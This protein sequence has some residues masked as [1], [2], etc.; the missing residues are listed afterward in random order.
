MPVLAPFNDLGLFLFRSQ[1]G[2]QIVF[3]LAVLAHVGE[4][5]YAV[6]VATEKECTNRKIAWFIQTLLL[7]YPSLRLLL[8]REKNPKKTLFLEK[9]GASGETAVAARKSGE[10]K[11]QKK[12]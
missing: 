4:A 3:L 6:R 9:Q 1:F 10:K 11:S 2:I 8:A 7:G 5:I 12:K